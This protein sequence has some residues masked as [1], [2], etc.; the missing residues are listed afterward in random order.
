MIF[1]KNALQAGSGFTLI[2]FII[3]AAIISILALIAAPFL[4]SLVPRAELRNAAGDAATAM[5]QARLKAADSQKP[6]RVVLDCR[7]HSLNRAK[8]CQARLDIAVFDKTGQ[9]DRWVEVD[10]SRLEL[11][12]TVG[13]LAAAGSTA[14]AKNPDH[15]FWAVFLPS[16]Q[17]LASHDPFN[18][19]F[20][21]DKLPS[22]WRLSVNK[23]SGRAT[24]LNP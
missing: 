24:L 22:T 4:I 17:V 8:P 3:V 23:H 14:V 1:K 6:S 13:V 15:V 7:D 21:S 11:A 5:R 19:V 18:L 2:E 9:L 20:S 10:G 16:S 12:V